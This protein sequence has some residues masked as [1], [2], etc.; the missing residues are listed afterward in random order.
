M[1]TT[2][3]I[4]SILVFLTADVR[5]QEAGRVESKHFVG[6]SAIVLYNLTSDPHPPRFALVTYGYRLTPKDAVAI[7][8]ITWR[9]YGP[10]GRQYWD[11]IDS[12]ESN[13][14]GHVRAS[15]VGLVYKRVLWKDL[16][17]ALHATP[18]FQ[19]Y[20]DEEGGTTQ[21]GFQLFNAARVGYEIELFGGRVFAQPSVAVTS[22][23][24][25]TNLPEDFQVEEDKWPSY[26]LFEPGLHVGVNL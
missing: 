17:A 8:A 12:P 13:F 15:G 3:L 19:E 16:Y 18:L 7:E 14:P 6:T 11:G 2:C 9:Y 1:K 24:I 23:P 22:W 4:V 5:A 25:H 20:V 26:F 10:L 21:T